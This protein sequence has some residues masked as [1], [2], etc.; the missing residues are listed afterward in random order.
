MP[1]SRWQTENQFGEYCLLKNRESVA[2]KESI[3][4]ARVA[5]QE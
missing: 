3:V 2:E 5:Q 4:A 1:G